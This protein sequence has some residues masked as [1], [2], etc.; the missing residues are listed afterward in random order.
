MPIDN[1]L[2]LIIPKEYFSITALSVEKGLC[3]VLMPFSL[4]FNEVWE[5]IKICLEL[6]L[7]MRCIRADDIYDSKPIMTSILEHIQ[8]AEIIIAD[9]T[10]RNPNVFYELGI[11]HTIKDNII[12]I[13]QNI[14]DIPFD[15]RH[16][17]C[18]KYSN[19][20]SGPENLKL[21]LK[22]AIENH[23]NKIFTSEKNSIV[24]E[25]DTTTPIS[26]EVV[27]EKDIEE[28]GAYIGDVEEHVNQKAKKEC[29]QMLNRI[30]PILAA[31]YG[32][33]NVISKKNHISFP[34]GYVISEF[35]RTW[36]TSY[37]V[38]YD[39]KT[40]VKLS[41]PDYNILDKL[42]LKFGS[43][44]ILSYE[45]TSSVSIDEIFKKSSQLERNIE[46][47]TEEEITLKIDDKLFI[48]INK[49]AEKTKL[50]IYAT[51]YSLKL[52]S[53]KKFTCGQIMS[54]LMDEKN[55]IKITKHS[56]VN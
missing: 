52:D 30:R 29:D 51:Y 44:N 9:L 33:K 10:G 42:T 12:L 5:K 48:K 47:L 36:G 34:A 45:F 24:S 8:K 17:Q 49:D 13:T 16:L 14:K 27:F 40:F 15:L 56:F 11:A 22:R 19:T 32:L 20:M 3:F 2:S 55:T 43:Y 25:K 37:D 1:K 28:G 39:V 46:A 38:R 21:S 26:V 7:G 50:S 41:P 4:K 6:D 18:I 35:E 54:W 23:S 53:Y 31:T